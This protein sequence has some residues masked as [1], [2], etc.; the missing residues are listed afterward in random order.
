[1]VQKY[2]LQGFN[3]INFSFC[4]IKFKAY[5]ITVGLIRGEVFY[6]SPFVFHLKL[7]KENESDSLTSAS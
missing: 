3:N 2:I 1:M 4:I 5:Q 6:T 7:K